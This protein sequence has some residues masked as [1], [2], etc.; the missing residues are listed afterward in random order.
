MEKIL[1]YI[2]HN[3]KPLWKVI[4]RC[5]E[6]ALKVLYYKQFTALEDQ[7][8]DYIHTNNKFHYRLI[9]PNDADM[10]Y[11]LLSKLD[12]DYV[13]FFNPHGFN[14]DELKRVLKSKNLITFGYFYDTELVGYF[15]LRLFVGKKAF[16]GY[17]VSPFY[18]GRGIGKDMVRILYG[19]ACSLSWDAYATISK[20]NIASIKLHN[21]QIVKKLPNEYVL[22]KY[23]D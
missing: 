9:T 15:M 19:I 16:L 7:Y 21:Y 3:L 22:L 23:I 14:R 2:K 4:E 6:L 5:N 11:D 18:S 12:K 8:R 17:V 20:N 13:K 1:L 10:L